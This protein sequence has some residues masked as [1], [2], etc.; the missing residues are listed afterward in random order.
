MRAIRL[1]SRFL[2][3]LLFIFS[4]FVKA[5]DPWGSAYKFSDYFHAFG[6]SFMESTALPLA[7]FISA[8][9]IVLGIVLILGYQKKRAYWALLLFMSFFYSTHFYSGIDKSGDRLRMFR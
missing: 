3:G 9:E 7:I 5:V 4:G 2:L 8:F 6:M 1:I